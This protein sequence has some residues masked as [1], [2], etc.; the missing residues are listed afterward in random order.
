MSIAASDVEEMSGTGEGAY[1]FA[2]QAPRD[3]YVPAATLDFFADSIL[4]RKG[5]DA[6]TLLFQGESRMKEMALVG[7]VQ[8]AFT[9]GALPKAYDLVAAKGGPSVLGWQRG[10]KEM[11]ESPA[12]GFRNIEAEFALFG[13]ATTFWPP[14]LSTGARSSDVMPITIPKGGVFGEYQCKSLQKATSVTA[15]LATRVIDHDDQWL[16]QWQFHEN[17]RENILKT[18]LAQGYVGA[19][20]Q[21]RCSFCWRGAHDH[22]QC[23]FVST[24]NKIREG[25]K[26]KPLQVVDGKVVREDSRLPVDVEKFADEVEKRLTLVERDIKELKEKKG[27][28]GGTSTKRKRESDPAEAPELSKRQKKRQREKARTAELKAAKK[29]GKGAATDGGKKKDKGGPKGG[30][31]GKGGSAATAT[32]SS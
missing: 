4:G 7:L 17:Q 5:G 2:C 15:V 32:A 18:V 13:K 3:W 9:D 19:K 24:Q 16:L 6:L 1:Y 20:W 14:P 25:L 27:G 12:G 28:S 10:T 23:S 8:R 29:G 11:L 31:G 21:K 22:T 30:K 26:L